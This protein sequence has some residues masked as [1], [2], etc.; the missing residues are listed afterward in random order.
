MRMLLLSGK[1]RKNGNFQGEVG[2]DPWKPGTKTG[3]LLNLSEEHFVYVLTVK[4]CSVVCLPAS[5]DSSGPLSFVP[6]DSPGLDGRRRVVPQTR[7]V[8]V[9]HQCLDSFRGLAAPR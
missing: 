7:C 9:L 8:A 3:T 6:G 1:C 2:A 4:R 5:S